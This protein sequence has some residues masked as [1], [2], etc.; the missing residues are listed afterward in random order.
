MTD[1]NNID[2]PD[3]QLIGFLFPS[4]TDNT[5]SWLTWP[6]HYLMRERRMSSRFVVKGVRTREFNGKMTVTC[7]DYSMGQGR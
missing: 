1:I 5:M 6:F 2:I 3:L 4:I 7:G